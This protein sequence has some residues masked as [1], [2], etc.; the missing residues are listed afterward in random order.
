M[1]SSHSGLNESSPLAPQGSS[2]TPEQFSRRDLLDRTS[3]A[4]I[5]VFGADAF[6]HVAGIG[7]LV[8]DNARAVPAAAI[9]DLL[10]KHAHSSS[11]VE[12][13]EAQL[14]SYRAASEPSE[15]KQ[16]CNCTCACTCDC[17]CV[18]Q[19]GTP[20]SCSCACSCSCN[21]GCECECNC[22]CSSCPCTT[23][24]SQTS[25]NSS[26]NSL[27]TSDWNPGAAAS[28]NPDAG[29]A[30]HGN[31]NA[32]GPS[33]STPG[34]DNTALDSGL[35][36]QADDM[37]NAARGTGGAKSFTTEGENDTTVH[38]IG[39]GGDGR[40]QQS[41]MMWTRLRGLLA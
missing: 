9:R 2:A 22:T 7:T 12:Q 13:A 29:A 38:F 24:A 6:S 34:S 21:C 11:E 5:M 17:N 32:S 33:L 37:T 4:L 36:T 14:E 40:I 35:V 41:T 31:W 27:Y 16:G 28:H 1:K 20:C 3:K 19:C 39:P 8:G 23:E 10:G 26:R 15:A 25:H 30:G 18:C